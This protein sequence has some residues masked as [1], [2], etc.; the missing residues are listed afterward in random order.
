MSDVEADLPLG[1]IHLPT[2]KILGPLSSV[3]DPTFNVREWNSGAETRDMID[4]A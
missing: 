2:A 3:G 4:T 1:H